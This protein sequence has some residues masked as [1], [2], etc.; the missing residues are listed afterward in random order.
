[1]TPDKPALAVKPACACT[2]ADGE[3]NENVIEGN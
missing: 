2:H 1:M 3:E